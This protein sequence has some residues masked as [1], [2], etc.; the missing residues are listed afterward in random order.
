MNSIKPDEILN[1]FQKTDPL[2]YPHLFEYHQNN[3]LPHQPRADYFYQLCRAIVG[4]QLSTKAA[5][6]IWGRFIQ[7]LPDQKITPEQLLQFQP[8]DLRQVGLS[9]AKV[10]YTQSLANAVQT[11]QLKLDQLDQ[12]S[13]QEVI[14]QLTQVKGIGT[15]TAEMFLMFTLARPNIFSVKD[16]GLKRAI[17]KLYQVTNPTAEQLE[18]IS[19]KWSPYRSYA[20]FA[21]WYSL[22]NQ[23]T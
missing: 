10:T 20:A 2:L 11:G 18:Q 15:W 12:L 7:L 3:P 8:D 14:A 22:D 23:P 16:L 21:L 6:T 5:A 9:R 13:D 19:L 17:E 1:H 4:Q